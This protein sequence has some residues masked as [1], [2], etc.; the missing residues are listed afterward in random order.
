MSNQILQAL[1]AERVSHLTLAFSSSK[2]VFWDADKGNLIHAGE[3]GVYR[4]RAVQQLLN[5]YTPQ[6]FGIGT[7]F[8]ITNQGSVSTQCDIVIY[9][10]SKMPAIITES[11]QAFYPVESVVAVCEVKSDINSLTELNRYLTKLSKVKALREEVTNPCPYRSHRNRVYSPE[12]HPYDQMFT[13]LICNKFNFEHALSKIKLNQDITSRN[14]HNLVLSISDGLFCYTTID[15]PP[16][17]YYPVSGGDNHADHWVKA[18]D[19][20]LPVHF[21]VLLTSLY[22]AMNSITLLKPDMALYLEDEPYDK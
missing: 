18:T 22:N 16:V 11:H 1:T 5:L 3:Y 2:S 20:K 15:G 12:K 13:F 4:E 21:K 8:I 7:G 9:D 17:F 6:Q 10:K 14:R 19:D